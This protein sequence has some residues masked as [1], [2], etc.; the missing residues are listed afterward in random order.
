[1]STREFLVFAFDIPLLDAIII[2]TISRS[3]RNF[4]R[5]KYKYKDLVVYIDAYICLHIFTLTCRYKY[6]YEYVSTRE[7][8]VFV[9]DIPLSNE[10][11][12]WTKSRY[13]CVNIYVLCIY[14]YIY[15]C[16]DEIC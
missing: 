14:V 6:I 8:L 11:T 16:I 9:F 2:W 15:I 5:C 4:Y 12:V 3:E 7:F 1:M 10:I 13:F